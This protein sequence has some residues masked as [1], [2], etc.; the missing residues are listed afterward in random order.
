MGI[1]WETM[2]VLCWKSLAGGV[3]AHETLPQPWLNVHGPSLVKVQA[4][5][6]TAVSSQLRSLCRVPAQSD[7]ILLFSIDQV[8]IA[9][10]E[11]HCEA[12]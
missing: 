3:G 7:F 12:L 1:Q 5:S 11:C 2:T 8:Q 4:G 6:Y 10:N 9:Q